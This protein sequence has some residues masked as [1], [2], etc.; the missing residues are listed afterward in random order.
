M[1]LFK[2][3]KN[4]KIIRSGYRNEIP[5]SEVPDNTFASGM[6]GNGFAFR[7]DSD[8]IFSALFWRSSG[9]CQDKTR[10]GH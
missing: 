1:H 8:M 4:N 10:C 6:M 2:T 9:D 3:K 7:F 5:L